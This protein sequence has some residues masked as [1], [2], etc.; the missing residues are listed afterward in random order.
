M[1]KYATS[2]GALTLFT[3]SYGRGTDFITRD[4][5]VQ[6]IGGSFVIQTF[7]SEDKSEEIQIKGRT[8][9]QGENGSFRIILNLYEIQSLG[10]TQQV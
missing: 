8:A 3:K 6:A 9:R 10:V 7:F 1:V 2:L 4:V 5:N